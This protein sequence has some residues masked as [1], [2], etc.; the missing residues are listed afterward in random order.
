MN[1]QHPETVELMK[2]VYIQIIEKR[3]KEAEQ[4]EWEKAHFIIKTA[5]IAR[6]GYTGL[7]EN[8][9]H[10]NFEVHKDKTRI[11]ANKGGSW[12]YFYEGTEEYSDL[13]KQIELLV[14]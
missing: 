7:F 14:N 11:T 9:W 3:K 6:F 8:G 4:E 10:F 5:K 2:N 1:E 13:I 12:K